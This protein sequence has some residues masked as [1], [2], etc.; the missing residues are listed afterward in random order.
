MKL[1]PVDE[2]MKIL[3]NGAAKYDMRKCTAGYSG[4]SLI[5]CGASSVRLLIKG[6][7]G[8]GDQARQQR[9]GLDAVYGIAE[10]LL[11]MAHHI[12]HNDGDGNPKRLHEFVKNFPAYGKPSGCFF[13]KNQVAVSAHFKDAAAGANEF[14]SNA[15]FFADFLRQTGCTGIIVSH[16]TVFNSHFHGFA[17]SGLIFQKKYT[18]ANLPFSN[19]QFDA[20]I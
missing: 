7:Q 4:F 13:G 19:G 8:D 14:R 3:Q 2:P 18:T 15:E 11:R 1:P 9:I 6:N 20:A 10:N 17:S 16:S 5:G 12:Q